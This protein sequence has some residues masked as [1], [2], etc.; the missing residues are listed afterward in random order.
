MTGNEAKITGNRL[1][2]TGN[3]PDIKDNKKLNVEDWEFYETY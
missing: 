1:V 2:Y 3:K